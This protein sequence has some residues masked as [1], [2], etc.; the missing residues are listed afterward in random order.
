V[1]FSYVLLG[2]GR[3]QALELIEGRICV[4][5]ALAARQRRVRLIVVREGIHPK[6]VAGLLQLAEKQ[7][8][9]I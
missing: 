1:G 9:P 2:T 8:V 3:E 7:G 5:A 4:E 6:R